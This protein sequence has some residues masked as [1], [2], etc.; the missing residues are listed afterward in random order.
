[1][2]TPACL[3]VALCVAVCA[4]AQA[5][6]AGTAYTPE[7]LD[8]M[9][10]PVALYPDPLISL[11]LPASTVPADISSAALYVSANGDPSG[12]DSQP[13]DPSVKGLAHYPDVLKWM[14]DN[15]DWTRALGAA[16]AMQPSDVM[17]SIQQL[18]AKARAAGTLVD[19]PQQQVDVEGD[20]IRI[21]PAQQDT[22]YVPE[23]NPDAVYGDVPEGFS[24][25]FIT[26]GVGFPVGA[27]LGFECDWDDFAIW[28][29][30]WHPGW[31]YR[32]DW[33]DPH[34]AGARWHPNPRQGH[35]LVRNFYRP[36]TVA[37]RPRPLAEAR[38]PGRSLVA[39]YH[40]PGP[41]PQSRPDYRGYAGAATRP[42]TP[43][44]RGDLYGGYSRGTDTRAYSTRGQSSRSAPVRKSAPAR[45][46]PARSSAPHGREKP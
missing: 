11:I 38:G 10:A 2:K 17:K 6:A 7:Q 1:M 29:G 35:A 19:T 16:F 27:W 32:R 30:P 24:G 21:I 45:S 25:P 40:P 41:A 9:L 43:A 31:G 34:F 23:Y 44:P 5:P 46:A 33:R 12:I 37:A 42:S 14:N 36:G 26:F 28:A 3:F 8:Q 15:L 4:R 13:W 18:R 39:T 22:I 20:D